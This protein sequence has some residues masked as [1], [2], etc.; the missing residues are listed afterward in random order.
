VGHLDAEPGPR[1]QPSSR[2]PEPRD[3]GP[4][5]LPHHH[6]AFLTRDG[7]PQMSFGVMGGNMQPQ[8]HLQTIVR[9]LDHRQHSAGGLRCAALALQ[10]RDS[11]STSRPRCLRETVRGLVERG[12]TVDVISDSYQDFGAGQFIWR[13]GDQSIEGYVAA[14]DSRRDGQAVAF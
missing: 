9:M 3:A 2:Q 7:K 1:L 6:P 5:P 8:A 10:S 13:L 4:T 12:T 11:R 14:S